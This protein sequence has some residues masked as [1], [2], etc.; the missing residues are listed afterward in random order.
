[1]SGTDL[2][3]LLPDLLPRLW[4]FAVRLTGDQHSA[5]DLIRR[6]CLRALECAD[7]LP[8]ETAPL[9]W[10]FSIVHSTWASE[11]PAHNTRKRPTLEW[12]SDL[13]ENIADQV[14]KDP[15]R[16]PTHT[17]II[18]TIERLPEPQRVVML[19]VAVE[20]LAYQQAAEVLGIPF[21]TL[22]SRVLRARQTIGALIRIP[23][24]CARGARM[25]RNS[26]GISRWR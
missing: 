25:Q 16:P 21:R 18:G 17:Q 3:S 8:A 24:D 6:A 15:E 20:G 1:M 14:G 11:F 9:S 5:E 12:D 2:R 19:L 4:A 13:L 26:G 23:D 7:Q 22:M 10:M